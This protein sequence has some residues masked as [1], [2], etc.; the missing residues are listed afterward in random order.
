M[1][2]DTTKTYIDQKGNPAEVIE[3]RKKRRKILVM[4]IYLTREERGVSHLVT[5]EEFE[6]IFDLEKKDEHNRD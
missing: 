2:I 4:F 1:I 3:I 5:L 6:Q